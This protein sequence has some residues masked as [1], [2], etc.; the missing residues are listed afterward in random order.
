L[1]DL[2]AIRRELPALRQ[3]A[4]LNSGTAGPWPTPVVQAITAALAREAELG[5]ASPRGLPDFPPALAATRDRLASWVGAEPGEMAVTGS[6]TIGVNI[7]VW[8]LDWQPGDEVVTSSIEHR[9]VLVPL[10]RLAARRGV[11]VRIA[12]LGSGQ[13]AAALMA[14][15]REL[16]ERTRLVALSHVSFSTGAC[17]PI[18]EIARAAHAVDA[19]VLVDGAQAVG[20]MPVDVRT[21]DVDYYAF[22]GQKW[23]CGPEGTGGLFIRRE[24]Q[25]ELA[26]TFVGTRSAQPGAAGYEYSTLFR[27]GVHGLLAAL[28]WLEG[29]GRDAIFQR[30][31]EQA[32]SCHA[33]LGEVDGVEVITPADSRA[34]LV[35]FR[36][37]DADLELAVA[38]LAAEGVTLRS[39]ADT[40]AL[41]VSC[42]FFNTSAEID[43]LVAA[44]RRL[45]PSRAAY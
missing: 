40:N 19:Q 18:A 9:G 14:I 43:Q 25:P 27:P 1:I 5:R 22:P 15:Q 10:Q 37:G 39:V 4:Y 45:S 32:N 38:Q 23:L 13:P 33:Q 11:R 2:D 31:A 34:G 12:Q 29:I 41:R 42:G 44:V 36:L 21:L 17:L 24:L 35:C 28:D 26:Q 6:T 20:A 16:S 3:T 8:G 30:V 7:V